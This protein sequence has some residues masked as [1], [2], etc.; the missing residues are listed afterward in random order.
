MGR[1][2]QGEENGR[3]SVQRSNKTIQKLPNNKGDRGQ[4]EL[5]KDGITWNRSIPI[6]P[7]CLRGG[8]WRNTYHLQVTCLPVP[9]TAGWTRW[10]LGETPL[11]QQHPKHPSESSR[12]S[13]GHSQRLKGPV[14]MQ[15]PH[16]LDIP[17]GH[18]HGNEEAELAPQESVPGVHLPVTPPPV[19]KATPVLLQ[20]PQGRELKSTYPGRKKVYA[21]REIS[22]HK[23][24]M[25]IHPPLKETTARGAG[26]FWGF[27]GGGHDLFGVPVRLPKCSPLFPPSR[28]PFL[29]KLSLQCSHLPHQLREDP[30]Y[31]ALACPSPRST[32]VWDCKNKVRGDLE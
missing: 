18:C 26:V 2:T 7:P 20:H 9:K 32:Y 1:K 8:T 5:P 6:L 30:H 23:T 31:Q 14:E 13:Q 10:T 29:P 16:L 21:Q 15:N 4:Q 12:A 3:I 19:A 27:E 11:H 25:K 22:E 28:K 24:L 17:L